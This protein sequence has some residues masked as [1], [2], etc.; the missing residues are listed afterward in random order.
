MFK[1]IPNIAL[2]IAPSGRSGAPF[3]STFLNV[4]FFG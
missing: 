1:Q 4:R 2:K 3:S